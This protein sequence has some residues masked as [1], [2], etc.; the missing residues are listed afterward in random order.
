MDL[1]ELETLSTVIEAGGF[2]KAAKRLAVTQSAVSQTIARMESKFGT[3]LVVRVTPPGLTPA[4]KRVL[5]FAERMIVEANVLERDLAD[6]GRQ[7]RGRVKIGASQGITNLHL[8]ALLAG[9]FDAFP[10]ISLD[11]ANLASR[12]LVLQVKKGALEVGFGVFERTMEDFVTHPYG[13]E[14][15]K[16]YASPN[17]PAYRGMR[18]GDEKAMKRALLLTSFLDPIENRPGRRRLRYRFAGVW[19]VVSLNL[20]IELITRGLGVGY[21]PEHVVERSESGRA[22]RHV[23]RFEHSTFERVFGLYYSKRR[24]P[25]PV[26]RDFIGYCDDH[27]SRLESR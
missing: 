24:T 11:V 5:Q 4:G 19:Q 10:G 3:P 17:H 18:K 1:H 9:L 23:S 15:M 25:T 26:A 16:L 21:L 13:H 2:N 20:R 27:F 6:M 12:E 7:S 14:T 8:P 22:L